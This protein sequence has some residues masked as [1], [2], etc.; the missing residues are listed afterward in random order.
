MNRPTLVWVSR[1]A[2]S[3][4]APGDLGRCHQPANA[5]WVLAAILRRAA[6]AG[7]GCTA[8]QDGMQLL[9]G[10]LRTDH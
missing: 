8:M 7:A 5:Q 2:Y 10:V 1:L 3:A 4:K 9:A 6:A